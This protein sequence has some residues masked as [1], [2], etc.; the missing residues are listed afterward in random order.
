MKS[1]MVTTK[2]AKRQK[3]NKKKRTFGSA[4]AM[5]LKLL[6][7]LIGSLL[8]ALGF[9]LFQVPHGIA[10]G[11]VSGIA[12]IINHFSDLP[13]GTLYLV[14]NLPLLGLGYVYLGRWKFVFKTLFSVT[15]FSVATDI[16]LTWLPRVL[17]Q[18][19]VSDDVL[20]C[21]VYAGVLSGVGAGIIYHAGSTNG[22]TAI[23]GRIIQLR[24][25]IPLSQVYLYTDGLIVL[26]AGAL[27]GWEISLYALLTL[28]LIGMTADY[29][30]EGP[31]SIR[32]ITIV[33]DVPDQVADKVM[34]HLRR[35]ISSWKITGTYTGREHTMLMCTVF[36]TQVKELRHL[37]HEAD[38]KAFLTIA[39]GHQAVGQGF[40]QPKIIP[41]MPTTA[42]TAGKAG[43]SDA[44][45]T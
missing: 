7:T 15:V 10:A 17:E 35:G 41:N 24:T 18:Y 21:S 27:F 16:F 45:A 34:H 2:K 19:P 28:V 12:I 5:V 3:P 20:L 6:T 11:G 44:P 40:I 1:K 32:V 4:W 38:P 26:T 33:T 42:G 39:T 23:V 8:I 9:T 14:M 25:G 22:G 30:L 37:V 43:V 13:I 31:S 36:R 29:V